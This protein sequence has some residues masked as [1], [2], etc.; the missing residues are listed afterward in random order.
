MRQT[1]K[2]RNLVRRIWRSPISA[3]GRFG[4][5]RWSR[6]AFRRFKFV[7]LFAAGLNVTGVPAF[8][9]PEEIRSEYTVSLLGL[10][11]AYLSFLTVLDG[12][13]YRISGKLT[14]SVLADIIEK[15]RG[16]AEVSGTVKQGRFL[17]SHYEVSYTSGDETHRTEMKLRNGHV[18]SAI[19]M[20]VHKN[21]S[22]DWVPLNDEYRKS[23]VDPLSGLIIPAGKAPCPRT[24]HIFDG[25]SRIDL[26]LEP[27]GIRPY[28]TR[29][30]SG[31]VTACS[32]RFVP[33]AGY[34]KGSSAIVY[35]K[36]QD[37]MEVWFAQQP[38]VGFYA[39]VYAK[40]PTKI[41][42]VIVAATRFG[43]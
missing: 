16:S 12:D 25:Q 1:S 26:V 41:G 18:R 31:D 22:P 38:E 20:P 42:P 33:R 10:P 15:T 4:A 9:E 11:V 30:F 17:A 39:P 36:Q 13:D 37:G 40:I 21:R 23:V 3:M 5:A 32:I 2:S 29:G 43:G 8:A 24:L 7:L 14:T 35:L 6:M 19:N 34:R 28:S 27:K